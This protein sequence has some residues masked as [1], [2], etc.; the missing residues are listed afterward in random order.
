MVLEDRNH[1]YADDGQLSLELCEQTERVT[2]D[3]CCACDEAK[4]TVSKTEK[5]L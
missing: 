4:Y 1:W 3:E 2:Q 5:F